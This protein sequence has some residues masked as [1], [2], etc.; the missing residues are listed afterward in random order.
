M[1]NNKWEKQ[2]YAAHE[3]KAEIKFLWISNKIFVINSDL[4]V[5]I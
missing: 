2:P 3:A 1:L 4:S 5:D